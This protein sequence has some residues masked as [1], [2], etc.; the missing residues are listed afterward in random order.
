MED[1]KEGHVWENSDPRF[2]AVSDLHNCDL[3]LEHLVSGGMDRS[4]NYI[5]HL[6]WERKGEEQFGGRETSL[7]AVASL[8]LQ[9]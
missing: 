1:P 7:G 9:Q 5:L 4:H 2:N 3:P 6:A 8:S